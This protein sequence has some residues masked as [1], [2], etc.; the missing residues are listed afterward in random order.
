MRSTLD[1]SHISA[2]SLHQIELPASERSTCVMIFLC[3]SELPVSIK[4]NDLFSNTS[5]MCQVQEPVL[6]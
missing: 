2:K 6:D 1:I 5:C 4:L 3:Q